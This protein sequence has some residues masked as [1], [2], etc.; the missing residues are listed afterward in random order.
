MGRL[1]HGLQP[2]PI[3]VLLPTFLILP[4]LLRPQASF[5]KAQNFDVTNSRLEDDHFLRDAQME[6]GKIPWHVNIRISYLKLLTLCLGD[7]ELHMM[8]A[9]SN[10]RL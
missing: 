4:S 9:S 7:Q 1:E 3:L 6:Y 2:F 5:Y 10:I 8:D